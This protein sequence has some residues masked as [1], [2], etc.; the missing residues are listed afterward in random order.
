MM[1]LRCT[2]NPD[3]TAPIA[4]VKGMVSDHIG[5]SLVCTYYLL[6]KCSMKYKVISH[7]NGRC[8]CVYKC[9][10]PSVLSSVF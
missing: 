3:G 1:E 2:G 4:D 10:I 6:Q 8:T 9:S 7:K 5:I